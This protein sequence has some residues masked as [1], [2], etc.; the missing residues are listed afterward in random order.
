MS[1]ADRPPPSPGQARLAAD[2]AIAPVFL[3]SL[4]SQ[5]PCPGKSKEGRD[6]ISTGVFG[7][8]IASYGQEAYKPS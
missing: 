4:L 3:A 1:E 5:N 2:I 7:G 8:S 6:I